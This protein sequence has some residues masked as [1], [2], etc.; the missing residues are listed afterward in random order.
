MR[1]MLDHLDR[2]CSVLVCA[3]IVVF[4]GGCTGG[5]QRCMGK[6]QCACYPNSTCD[7]GLSCLSHLCVSA[8]GPGGAGAGG[9]D[10]GGATGDGGG[11]TPGLGGPM[12][13]GPVGTAG[14]TAGGAGAGS[15]G[16]KGGASG[17]GGT[18]VGSGGTGAGGSNPD[19]G[20]CR[21]FETVAGGGN[22]TPTVFLLVDRSGSMFSCADL[23]Q[24]LTTCADPSAS[25][26][27]VLRTGILQVVQ[28]LQDHVRFGFGAFTGT[29][30]GAALC[31]IFDRVPTALGNYDAIA[32]V[33][34]PLGALGT[35]AETPVGGALEKVKATLDAEASSGPKYI[36]FVTDGEP[37]FCD[38]GDSICPTDSVIAHLQALKTQGITT[39]IFGI[40][41]GDTTAVPLG[42]LQAFANAG[43][44]QPVQG[45]TDP[46][47]Y[48]ADR[49]SGGTAP[50]WKAEWTAAGL[51]ARTPLG[52]YAATGGT[53]TVY[54]P[55]PA[56]QAALGALLAGTIAG[57]KSCTFDLANGL[58]VD[59]ARAAEA[60]VLIEGALIPHD[61][62]N[63]WR[64]VS[65][66]QL[67]LAGTACMVWRQPS[68]RSI[69]FQFPCGTVL[70]N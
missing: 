61:D 43:G 49:C 31:P 23:P 44:G 48:T 39:L 27:A 63:G 38:D 68:S 45:L 7:V 62:S 15:G 42:T 10:R 53:A 20:S 69:D 36:L 24:A 13:G 19:G 32:A 55:N 16:A 40:Q 65:S 5:S 67:A 70:G 29:A 47:A 12:G 56:D 33:Y 6:E 9:G 50:Q 14:G 41:N 52:T 34:N 8:G 30:G 64:M 51:P 35:K 26:W 22:L 54:K 59:L 4:G 28:Q 11:G 3:V 37:D 60:H 21:L 25:I 57:V 66:T 18:Q 58:S 2:F 17:G 46:I 1:G